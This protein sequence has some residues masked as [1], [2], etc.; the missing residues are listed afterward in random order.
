MTTL[1]IVALVGVVALGIAWAVQQRRPDPPTRTGAG[2]PEQLDRADFVRPDAPWL[3]V[4]FTSAT[5]ETCADMWTKV[6]I[7]DSADVAVQDVEYRRDRAL[8]DRYRI[9]AVPLVLVAD[10]AGVVH[11]SFLGPTAAQHLW[12]AVAELREPG[13]VPPGCGEH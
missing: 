5:C 3:V 11:K 9:D 13:S 7:L 8:H 12:A 6:A 1:A 4:A 2:V 10:D